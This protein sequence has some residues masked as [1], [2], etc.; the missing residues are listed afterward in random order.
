MNPNRYSNVNV[1]RSRLNSRDERLKNPKS[2]HFKQVRERLKMS[3]KM[4]D[5]LGDKNVNY[6]SKANQKLNQSVENPY[7]T[8]LG[9][10]RY[11]FSIN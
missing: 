7:N 8:L 5:T 4:N 3:N 11:I 9:D 2:S 10:K 1:S 6:T